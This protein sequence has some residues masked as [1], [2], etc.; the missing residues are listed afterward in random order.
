MSVSFRLNAQITL[1]IGVID[2]PDGALL[3]GTRLAADHVNEAGGIIGADGTVFQLSV[4]DTPPEHMDIAIA[5]MRQASVIAVIGPETNQAVARNIARLQ[6]LDVPVLTPATGDTVLLSDASGRIFRSRAPDRLQIN[7]LVDYLVDSLDIDSIQTIQLDSASTANLIT[8]ANALVA[9]GI[10]PTNL[11]YDEARLN[12]DQIAASIAQS[13]PDVAAVFGPPSLA[14]RAFNA[15][16]TAGYLGEVVYAQATDPAFVQLVP[17]TALSG[18]ISMS[19]WSY[20]LDDTASQEFVLAYARAFGIL[21]DALSAAGYDSVRLVAEAGSGSGALANDLAAIQAFRGVQGQLN[22]A[23]LAIGEISNNVVVTRLNEYGAANVVARYPS[24]GGATVQSENVSRATATP[25]PTNTPFPTLTP[26][27]YHLII[28]SE[29]QNVRSGPGLDYEIIGQALQGAQ[30]RV[31]GATADY[32][33]L[34]IDYRGQWGWM[35]AYLV[36][37]IG[38]RNL[39]PIIEP[40]ATS[41]P[42]PA[43]TAV[44]SREPD[45]LV[46][47]ANPARITLGQATLVNVSVQNRGLSPAGNFAIAGTFEPGGHYVG[48]NHPG[49]AAGQ[50]TVL[51]LRPTLNGASGP[52]SVIIVV[53][54]NQEVAEGPAGEAN[55]QAFAYNYIADRP[56][57]TSGNW[58]IAPGSFDLDG[59]ALSEFS[60]TGNEVITQGNAA[61]LLM[62]QFSSL[63]DAHYDA[64]AVSQANI[65]T[66][67]ADQLQNATIGIVTAD[68]HR[69]VMRFTDVT[70]NGSLT[71]EYRI[72]R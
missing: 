3:A 54:L 45:L 8:L 50:Q 19:T 51:Q 26:T 44:P 24:Q 20:S 17:A 10:R 32:K 34:V 22:P 21:P 38:N 27:G 14:A 5:N 41:T 6:A 60:W 25:H 71:V 1:R 12:L 42:A 58:R 70:R 16:Q 31:L 64:I 2:R 9:H 59:D 11:R 63:H 57:L 69:G 53:D 49:L 18:I 13:A 68:G 4:V 47:S 62:N 55:N 37:T 43:A 46:L 40:P 29:F 66:L 33:W 56:V 35:A 48:I 30:L 36:E 65:A 39:V 15:M 72:Y 67:N 23:T 28:Q 52:Q 61:M 7:G